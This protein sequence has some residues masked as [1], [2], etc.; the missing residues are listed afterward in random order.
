M[1][2]LILFHKILAASRA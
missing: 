1:K 2:W